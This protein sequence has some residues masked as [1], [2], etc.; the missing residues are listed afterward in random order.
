MMITGTLKSMATRMTDAR[1][2]APVVRGLE[3]NS[4]NKAR[5]R[6]LAY[7]RIDDQRSGDLYYPG[8]ISTSPKQFADQIEFIANH[9]HVCSMNDVLAAANGAGILPGDSVLLTFDDATVDFARHAWPVLQ[10]HGLPATLFVA[11]AYP[12][13]PAMSFWWDKLYRAILLSP[14]CTCIPTSTG[15][16]TLSAAV[17]RQQLFRRLKEYFKTIPHS[18][19]QQQLG[20][21][22]AAAAVADPPHNNVLSWEALRRLDYEG[23]TL[24]PHTHTHPMLN[25]LSIDEIHEELTTSCSVL[26]TQ[27]GHEISRTLAYPAGGVSDAVV[28]AMAAAGLSLGFTTQRGVNDQRFDNPCR[29]RRIN[30]GAKTTLG[31]LRLQ[32]A[33]WGN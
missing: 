21:I 24:A 18:Q 10:S 12:D 2:F 20:G 8:L 32:L 15:S 1:V 4:R 19:F 14:D 3:R 22:V 23:V 26:K 33:N 25:Q 17:Q 30:V 11:T 13:N 9:Y 7:H 6:V 5:L 27:I 28:S 31:L 29:L 16:V